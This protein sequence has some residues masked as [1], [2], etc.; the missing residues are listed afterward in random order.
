[1]QC[2]V[3]GLVEEPLAKLHPEHACFI[4]QSHTTLCNPVDLQPARLLC[5][6]D[7]PGKNT[8]VGCHVLLQ[9]IFPTQGLNPSLLCL[10]HCRRILYPWSPTPG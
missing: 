3:T 9:G 4:A 1:M 8:G 10:L 6:E 2:S 5:P 7:S